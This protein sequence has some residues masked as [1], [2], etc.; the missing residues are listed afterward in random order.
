MAGN[1]RQHLILKD[2]AVQNL[3]EI[4]MLKDIELITRAANTVIQG[5]CAAFLSL[6]QVF[7]YFIPLLY[8]I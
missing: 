4:C 5:L 7:C 1:K 2:R 3:F 8:F 6:F